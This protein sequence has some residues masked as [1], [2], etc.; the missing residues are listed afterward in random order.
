MKIQRTIAPAAA[1]IGWIDL[2]HGLTGFSGADEMAG[3]EKEFREHFG[4]RHLFFVSSGKAAFYLIL[5][6]LKSLHPER[7]EVVIP[8]YTCFSVPSAIMKAGLK[9]VPC[10]IDSTRFD[11]NRDRLREALNERTLCVVPGHLFGIPSD[12]D[13][14]GE[15]C[16]TRG[17][18][19]VEDAAQSMGGGYKGR[20]LG[21]IGD[22][23]FFSFGRGKNITC[24][25]G[26]V[27]LTNQEVIA[28]AIEK[29][30]AQIPPPSLFE[31]FIEFFKLALLILLIRPSLF[32]LPT[33]IPFLKLGETIFYKD[34]PV[35]RLSR[36]KA[37]ILKGWRHRLEGSNRTRTENTRF[38]AGESGTKPAVKTGGDVFPL[39]LPILLKDRQ[40]RDA[41]FFAAR[42]RGLGLSRMYPVPVNEIEEIKDQFDHVAFPVAKSLSERLLNIPTHPLLS[43][44]DRERICNL[45]RNKVCPS[46]E[47]YSSVEE[48]S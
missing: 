23:G 14:V 40:T 41:L 27:I 33:A 13:A 3:R 45:L 8:A 16:S 1:P 28:S 42:E 44:K 19:V 37:G 5:R 9:V 39:R 34:F 6:A 17:I 22:V 47:A 2:W 21:T 7:D 25:A 10:E 43:K 18:A 38:I 30:Y 15:L 12:M 35:Q 24:G 32:W 46:N 48:M 36:F 4:V 20:K 31:D 26:G 11:F 29:E